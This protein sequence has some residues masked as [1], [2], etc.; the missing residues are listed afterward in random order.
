MSIWSLNFHPNLFPVLL[1]LR[2]LAVL[3]QIFMKFGLLAASPLVIAASLL[4]WRAQ[5]V[6]EKRQAT[7]ATCCFNNS[8]C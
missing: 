4:S 1:S 8:V 3:K 5:I 7:R 2:G 6:Y